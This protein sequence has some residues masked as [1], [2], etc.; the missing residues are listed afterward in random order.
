MYYTR[1]ERKH[2]LR[3]PLSP[4]HYLSFSLWRQDCSSDPPATVNRATSR[5]FLIYEV[6]CYMYIS[7]QRSGTG[8]CACLS[9]RW[10]LAECSS[11][12]EEILTI[13]LGGLI[14]WIP[15][16]NRFL[17]SFCLRD[18]RCISLQ[19]SEIDVSRGHEL[20]GNAH[21][22]PMTFSWTKLRMSRYRGVDEMRHEVNRSASET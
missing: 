10:S 13:G 11:G 4:F 9:R 12:G 2:R 18:A 14:W 19:S 16:S 8:R 17:C 6:D 21:K 20:A 15:I 3:L 7:I 22:N 5:R 1:D